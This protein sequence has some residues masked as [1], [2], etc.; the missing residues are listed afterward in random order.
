MVSITRPVVSHPLRSRDAIWRHMFGSILAQEIAWCLTAP[1]YYLNQY[2]LI[3]RGILKHSCGGNL[4]AI[5]QVMNGSYEFK[6]D[7]FIITTAYPKCQ[8]VTRLSVTP[9]AAASWR[10]FLGILTDSVT[11]SLRRVCGGRTAT[12]IPKTVRRPRVFFM[13]A[14]WRLIVFC[15]P[16]CHRKPCDFFKVYIKLFLRNCKATATPQVTS[17]DHRTVVLRSLWGDVRFWP[18]FG[19]LEDHTAASRWFYGVRKV[20]RL[21]YGRRNILTT[22]TAAHKTARFSRVTFTK[23]ADRIKRMATVRRR[24]Y[25][26]PGH[27]RN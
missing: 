11:Y 18:C 23:T 17:Q 24:H 10:L 1:S 15:S 20:I 19:C 26:W 6:N 22:N 7:Q 4:K 27:W 8:W 3:G 2:W 13:L 5:A 14:E 16:Q 25:L 9:F 12:L 21:P